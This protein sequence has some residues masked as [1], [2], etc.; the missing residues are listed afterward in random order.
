MRLKHHNHDSQVVD[1]KRHC[2]F[3]TRGSEVRILSPNPLSPTIPT[4]GR[5]IT[6]SEITEFC[7]VNCDVQA[8]SPPAKP[9]K[10]NTDAFTFRAGGLSC[11]MLVFSGLG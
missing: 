5:E 4:N 11:Y 9:N 6:W 1:S 2:Q 3:G 10:F 7:D 8:Q